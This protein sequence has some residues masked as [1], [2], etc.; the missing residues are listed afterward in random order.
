MRHKHHMTNFGR[1]RNPPQK[2]EENSVE[3]MGEKK[4]PQ[5]PTFAGRR[6]SPELWE[7]QPRQICQNWEASGGDEQLFL[8]LPPAQLVPGKQDRAQ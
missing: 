2:E 1:L 7:K 3:E 5:N 6:V 8:G 4:P